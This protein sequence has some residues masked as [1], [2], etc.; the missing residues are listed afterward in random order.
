MLDD[1]RDDAGYIEDDEQDFENEKADAR[2]KSQSQLLGM[3][4]VQRLVIAIM[5][6]MMTCILGSFF[7]LITETVWLPLST[8]KIFQI[9]QKQE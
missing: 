2:N 8:G 9:N 6:F 4:P 7:L 3:T 5:I 1:L